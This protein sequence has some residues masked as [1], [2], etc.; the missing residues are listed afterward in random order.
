MK[1]EIIKAYKKSIQDKII[2]FRE[3]I[4]GLSQDAQNDA[5]SSAGD[6]HET[7]LSMMHLEQEKLNAKLTEYTSQLKELNE[8]EKLLPTT[9][10]KRGALI[11]TEFF[12]FLIGIALPQI[13][14]ENKKV[15]GISLS[16]PLAQ[17]LLSKSIGESFKIGEKLQSIVKIE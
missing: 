13:E 10:V 8:I 5:K 11:E 15:F 16:A 4:E 9:I 17:I 7:A 2:T 12:C 6:K 14:V 3:R 1:E